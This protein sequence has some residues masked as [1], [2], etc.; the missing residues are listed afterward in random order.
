[1]RRIIR[2]IFAAIMVS[3]WLLAAASLHVLVLPGWNFGVV[4]KD[5]LSFTDTYVDARAWTAE[6]AAQHPA[7]IKRLTEAGRI[8]WLSS[9]AGVPGKSLDEQLSDLIKNG[10]SPEK[11]EKGEK[12]PPPAVKNPKSGH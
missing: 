1:M 5:H 7:L 4:P 8:D 2:L 3:G 6:D 12:S 10:V 11:P 9:I